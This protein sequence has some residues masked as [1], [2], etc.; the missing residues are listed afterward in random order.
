MSC[1]SGCRGACAYID[2]CYLEN[3]PV[4]IAERPQPR[5]ASLL[6]TREPLECAS[7]GAA[8]PPGLPLRTVRVAI[9]VNNQCAAPHCYP[10]A[11]R[12]GIMHVCPQQ[13]RC[14]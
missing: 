2:Y 11:P 6:E 3:Q 8:L 5:A 1:G 10:A 9:H 4:G 14:G 13:A 7:D 12:H